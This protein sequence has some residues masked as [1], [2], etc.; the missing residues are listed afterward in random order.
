M[1]R[2]TVLDELEDR[3][4]WSMSKSEQVRNMEKKQDQDR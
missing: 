1:G 4:L 2:N 3:N